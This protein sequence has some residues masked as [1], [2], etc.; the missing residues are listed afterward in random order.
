MID[1]A[2][3]ASGIDYVLR[4]EFYMK[5]IVRRGN[6]LSSEEDTIASR[7]NVVRCNLPFFTQE[8]VLVEKKVLKSR[9]RKYL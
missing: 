3:L 2:S 5:E 8:L 7:D 6:S 9:V 4:Y 1:I